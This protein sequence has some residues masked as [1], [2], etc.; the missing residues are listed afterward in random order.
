MEKDP[1]MNPLG[2][3]PDHGQAVT[4]VGVTIG[5][6]GGGLHDP[7]EVDLDMIEKL[8]NIEIGDT[9]FFLIRADLQRRRLQAGQGR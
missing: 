4:A 7:L 3:E 8:A 9:V 1:D 5:N 2:L 6:A